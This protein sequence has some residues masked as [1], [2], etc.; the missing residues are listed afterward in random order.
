M[1][2]PLLFATLVLALVTT[3]ASAQTAQQ[4]YAGMQTRAIKALSEQQIA[5]IRNA[6]GMG[7]ALA[8][9]LNGYPGPRHL[10]EFAD[11]LGLTEHQRGSIERLFKSMEAETIPVGEALIAAEAEF[12][13]NFAVRSITEATLSAQIGAIGEI[14]ARLRYAHLRYHLATTEMLT[15][16]QIRQYAELRGYTGNSTGRHSQHPR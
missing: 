3:G 14:Q 11:Q 15:P 9:E 10:L 6:R 13:R 8:A 12:D 5:D 2:K 7:L 1:V 4:P 16:V